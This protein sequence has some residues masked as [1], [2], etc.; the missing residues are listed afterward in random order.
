MFVSFNDA[1]RLPSRD[2]IAAQEGAMERR[3]KCP[4]DPANPNDG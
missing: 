2:E 4:E 3:G 1:A